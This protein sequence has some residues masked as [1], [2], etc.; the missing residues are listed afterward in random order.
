MFK[1]L[2]TDKF[3]PFPKRRIM[4]RVVSWEVE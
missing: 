3:N 2:N 1:M 4:R